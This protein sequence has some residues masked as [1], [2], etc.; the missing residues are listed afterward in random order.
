MPLAYTQHPDKV[1]AVEKA[2]IFTNVMELKSYLGLLTY[3]QEIPAKLGNGAR[4]LIP[5]VGKG[6]A[7]AVEGTTGEVISG[8]K[9]VALLITTVDTFQPKNCLWHATHQHTVFELS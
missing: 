1:E 9:A 3:Y 8:L 7:L 4:A 5:V 2:P 6:S